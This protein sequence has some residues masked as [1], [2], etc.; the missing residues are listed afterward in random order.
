MKIEKL[1]ILIV[2]AFLMSCKETPKSTENISK[3]FYNINCFPE[4]L[5]KYDENKVTLLDDSQNPNKDTIISQIEKRRDVFMPCRHMIYRVI[6]KDKSGKKITNSRIKMM[7]TG[8][9]WDVQPEKQ[10]EILI[11]VEYSENDIIKPKNIN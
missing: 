8:K 4:S 10:D 7:A 9:R 6:W 5:P 11:Q 3:F 1:I 2:A